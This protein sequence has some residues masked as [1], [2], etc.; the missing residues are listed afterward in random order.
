MN[1]ISNVYTRRKKCQ[2]FAGD[3]KARTFGNVT[4][5][6]EPPNVDLYIEMYAVFDF[7]LS[8]FDFICVYGN[9]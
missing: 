6:C 2:L 8:I 9:V 4:V 5:A 1:T 3:R 7:F